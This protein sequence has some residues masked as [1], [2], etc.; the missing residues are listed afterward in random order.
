MMCKE[1][2]NKKE[3]KRVANEI[4]KYAGGDKKKAAELFVEYKDFLLKDAIRDIFWIQS[5]STSNERGPP[6]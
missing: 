2:K 6:P 4:K 5:G 1:K 3:F